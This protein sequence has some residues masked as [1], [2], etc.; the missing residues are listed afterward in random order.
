MHAR[1]IVIAA[2]VALWTGSAPAAPAAEAQV[3]VRGG[4]LRGSSADGVQAFLGIPYAAP[5]VGALR[6]QAPQAPA[7]WSGVRDAT[8]FGSACAQGDDRFFGLTPQ[9]R[10]EDCL[11]LNVWTPPHAAQALPVMVWLHGGAHR[12]GAASLAAYDGARLAARGVVVVTLNYRL[13]YLGYFAHPALGADGGNFGLM[14]QIAAL[15]WV[16][17]NI[18]AFGG[19]PAQVTV[20]GESAGGADILYLMTHPAGRGLFRAAI[21][22]SGGGW[23]KPLPRDKMQDKV[24]A[25][26]A[27]VGVARDLDAAALRA[28]PAQK[29]IDAQAA[30][31]NLGFG[32]FLDGRTVF[33][34]PAKVFAEG[35]QQK[36]PLIIGSNDGEGS[37]LRFRQP[38][39]R[40]RLLIRLPMVSGWYPDVE[41]D[42]RAPLLFRDA[43]FA[44][45]AR[46]IAAHHAPA[47]LYRY[48][49]L[50]AGQR[51]K[52]PGAGHAAEIAYVFDTLDSLAVFKIALDDEDRR[53]ATQLADCWVSF[54][55]AARPDCGLAWSPYRRSADRA[56]LIGDDAR[57]GAL[58]DGAALDGVTKY[59]GPGGWFGG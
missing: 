38:G 59:F 4:A 31:R 2:L 33:E 32:P 47:W 35:R 37:L 55:K 7:A 17:D 27:G 57:E 18:A 22:E 42:A 45:P 11:Y 15:A 13:G 34:A 40:D 24:V 3:T 51:G 58:P 56:L 49:H 5:P 36:L 54:A 21:V 30:D 9:R 1:R 48:A 43:V 50:S 53:Q 19:D 25:A 23:G 6:W 46:W 41:A 8:R 26:L 39:W 20:F 28:L 12:M 16:R 44:A 29:L 14:D 52:A 10:G